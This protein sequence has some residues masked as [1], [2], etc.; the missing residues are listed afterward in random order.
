MLVP[1]PDGLTF[2]L[3]NFAIIITYPYYS[4]IVFLYSVLVNF[5]IKVYINVLI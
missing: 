5:K 3:H 1:S 2:H 4:F